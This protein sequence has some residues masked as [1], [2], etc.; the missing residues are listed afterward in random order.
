[1]KT[2][3]FAQFAVEEAK[4]RNFLGE[5]IKFVKGDWLAGSDKDK[6]PSGQRFVAVLDTLTVGH[7]KWADGKPVD[8]KMGLV[9][10]GFKPVPRN[11]LGDLDRATWELDENGRDFVD[12]WQKTTLFVLASP[13]APHDLY[14]FTTSTVGGKGAVAALCEAHARTTEGVGQYP[15]VTLATDSYQHKNRAIGRVKTPVF[16]IV[17]CVEAAPFNAMI[18][19]ARGG[20]VFIPTSSPALVTSGMIAI[21]SGRLVPIKAA[22]PPA[23]P[24][25]DEPDG[26]GEFDEPIPF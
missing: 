8:S 16:E 24:I 9:A 25:D 10:D 1:M 17:D 18:V 13:V 14:T 22:G 3:M 5:L 6:I 7:I 26:P 21:T 15:V 2:S 4:N 12:P 20:A 19:G 23:P 11:E